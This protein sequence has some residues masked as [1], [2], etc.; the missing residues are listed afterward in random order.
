MFFIVVNN[1]IYCLKRSF[2]FYLSLRRIRCRVLK[3]VTV[4]STQLSTQESG[5]VGRMRGK[6]VELGGRGLKQGRREGRCISQPH[7]CSLCKNIKAVLRCTS[8][9]GVR[10][11]VWWQVSKTQHICGAPEGSSEFGGGSWP[12]IKQ[13]RL[14]LNVAA[15]PLHCSQVLRLCLRHRTWFDLICCLYSIF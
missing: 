11:P 13:Q 15:L 4:Q 2:V 5:G 6:G 1:I 14:W 8:Q 10:A 3:G 7:L 9:H 12:L